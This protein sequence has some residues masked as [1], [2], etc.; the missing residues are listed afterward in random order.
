MSQHEIGL[1]SYVTLTCP[2][3]AGGLI[4]P[5]RFFR[6]ASKLPSHALEGRLGTSRIYTR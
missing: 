5:I 6:H 3:K 1:T 4:R 2:Y